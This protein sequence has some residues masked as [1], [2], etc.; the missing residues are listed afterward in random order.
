MTDE[1]DRREQIKAL[2]DALGF[3]DDKSLLDNMLFSMGGNME[4][5]ESGFDAV[6][7]GIKA[8]VSAPAH[9]PSIATGILVA[10][11]AGLDQNF[12]DEDTQVTALLSSAFAISATHAQNDGAT[13]AFTRVLETLGKHAEEHVNQHIADSEEEVNSILDRVLRE[14]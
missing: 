8:R 3:D 6:H 13:V 9:A 11:L 14:Q 7:H 5:F 2:A 1:H 12:G 10:A 4:D